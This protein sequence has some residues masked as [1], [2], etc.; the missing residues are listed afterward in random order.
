MPSNLPTPHCKSAALNK[1]QY[2]LF[3]KVPLDI[4][5]MNFQRFLNDITGAKQL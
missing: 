3:W 5:R 2:M 4:F 1:L